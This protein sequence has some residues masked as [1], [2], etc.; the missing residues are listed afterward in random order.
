MKIHVE[1]ATI[2]RLSQNSF[3]AESLNTFITILL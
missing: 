3:T 2:F 1:A